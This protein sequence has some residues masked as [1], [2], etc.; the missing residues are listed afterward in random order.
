MTPADVLHE[1][2]RRWNAGDIE[3]VLELYT[4]DA[5][6]I[7][8]PD[9][10]EQTIWRGREAIRS[11]IDDWRAVWESAELEL[12]RIETFGDRV[13]A[14][15]AWNTRGRSSGVPGAMP[16][17][18]LSTIRHGKI[19]SLEWFTDHDAAVAAARGS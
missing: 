15:G 1:L 14:D 18:T 17:V 10:P 6:M 19:A 2:A 9:W 16:V 4:D 12:R 3:G 5:V 11:N 13:V 8:G 7:S